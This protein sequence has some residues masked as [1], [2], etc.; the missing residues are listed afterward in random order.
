VDRAGIVAGGMGHLVSE[1]PI[2]RWGAR[3]IAAGCEEDVPSVRQGLGPD[4]IGELAGVPVGVHAQPG[5]VRTQ[6]GLEPAAYLGPHD[7]AS[8][9][10]GREAG[11]GEAVAFGSLGFPLRRTGLGDHEG[12][13]VEQPGDGVVPG[14]PLQLG[15]RRPLH[16]DAHVVLVVV[17]PAIASARDP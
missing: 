13:G 4:G 5:E 3:R 14:H 8:R 10:A 11:G 1:E 16:R 6:V 12:V 7:H 15:D 9:S 2:T 17:E